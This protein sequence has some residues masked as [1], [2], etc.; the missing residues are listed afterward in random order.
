MKKILLA[1]FVAITLAL[2]SLAFAKDQP[3]VAFV[4]V[5]PVGDGG[6][7]YAQCDKKSLI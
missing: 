2:P 5:G 7:T 6:W 4:Y 3:K 1:L